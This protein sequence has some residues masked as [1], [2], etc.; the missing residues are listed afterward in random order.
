MVQY[1]LYKTFQVNHAVPMLCDDQVP[2]NEHWEF[3]V[4]DEDF[5][6]KKTIGLRLQQ[7]VAEVHLQEMV[8]VEKL[9]K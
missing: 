3:K 7:F 5:L 4:G 6:D 8:E 2:F 9:E 1:E